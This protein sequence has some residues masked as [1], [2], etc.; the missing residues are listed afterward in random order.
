MIDVISDKLD[1]ILA[2][3]FE[4]VVS[5]K[6]DSALSEIL[7][8]L[9]EK[10]VKIDQLEQ[11]NLIL[12]RDILEL[13]NRVDDLESDKMK[14]TLI[15]SGEKLPKGENGESTAQVVCDVLQRH[16]NYILPVSDISSAYRIGKKSSTQNPDSRPIAVKFNKNDLGYDIK[17]AFRE[18]K[19]RNL[20]INES[21]T[22]VRRRFLYILR[23]L[24]KKFPQSISTCGSQDG[25]I[26]VWIK[27]PN[28]ST[29]D[30]KVFITNQ[31]KLDEFCRRLSGNDSSNF[32]PLR[33]HD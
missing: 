3:K 2:E 22:P 12:K 31:T 16:V 27:S 26:Y 29:R 18:K 25:K 21:L 6:I 4:R 23:Q 5:D 24:K 7:A 28:G 14:N 9:S 30:R 19:P 8:K 1:V 13:G 11:E 33:H 15:L 17:G 20:F 10:D 32:L